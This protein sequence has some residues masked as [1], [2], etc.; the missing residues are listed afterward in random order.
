M[1]VFNKTKIAVIVSNRK[2][3]LA[4]IYKIT[5]QAKPLMSN[6]DLDKLKQRIGE[7]AD[8]RDWNQF[9]S[10]KNLSMA[11]SVEV[12]EVVEHFQWLT[13]EQSKNLPQNKLDE[14]EAELADTFIYLIRMADKLDIDLLSATMNK[15]AVNEQKYP[16]EKARGNAKK[17]TEL[18]D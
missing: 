13:E 11:L 7:F 2:A 10:P 16:V 12:A 14:V 6:I 8:A 15:I 18:D 17:Y 5:Q 4:T 1:S 3:T 9:H